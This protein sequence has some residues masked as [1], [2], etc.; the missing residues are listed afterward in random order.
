MSGLNG[1]HV[2]PGER[3]RA[4][5]FLKGHKSIGGRKRG[6]RNLLSERFLT[7]L[8]A[9]WV[10]SGKRVL[11]TVAQTEPAVFLK[12]VAGVMPRLI[13]VDGQVSIR[14]E[15]TVEAENFATAYRLWGQHI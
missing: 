1:R 3:N 6:S 9:Q 14:S 12:V 5:Q 15:L 8:H 11:E 7:D 4:G 10:K 13:D 2:G